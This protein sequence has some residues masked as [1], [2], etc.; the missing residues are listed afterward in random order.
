MD[1]W[2]ADYVEVLENLSSDNLDSLR[3]ITSQAF[4]FRDPF[5]HTHT[6]ADFVAIMQDMFQRLSTV[7]FQVHRSVQHNHDAF[8]Y[9]TFYG[10]SRFTG[11]FS[12]EGVSRIEASD[13]GKVILH[14]DFWDGSELM[15]KVPLLGAV[16]RKVRRKLSHN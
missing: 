12:F 8:I 7:R 10:H 6:Q 9:W 13:S 4:S 14:H 3:S 5:N 15:E 2:L 11:A 16:I 1:N